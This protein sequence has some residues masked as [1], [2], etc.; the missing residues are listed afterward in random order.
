MNSRFGIILAVIIIGFLGILFIGKR[1]S[2]APVDENGNAVQASSYTYGEGKANVTLV[3]YGD[4]ECPGCG[5]YFPI[6]S[7]LKEKY[8]DQITFQFRNFPLS[9]LHPNAMAAH[10]AAVAAEKQGKFWEMHDLLFQGQSTWNAQSGNNFEQATTIF[11]GFAEQLELDLDTYKADRDSAATNS[12]IQ[13]DIKAGKDLQVTGTPTFF[14]NG[15]Q[16]DIT[17][18]LDLDAFSKIIDEAIA[19]NSS[20]E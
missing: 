5:A 10:R 7:Q 15:E 16:L 17:G 14:L 8:K 9:S 4:F 3:E 18:G 20:Q 6:V 2:A 13:A 11:E 12:L 1:D 19:K